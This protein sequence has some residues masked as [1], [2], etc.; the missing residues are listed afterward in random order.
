MPV[1]TKHQGHIRIGRTSPDGKIFSLQL[2][3]TGQIFQEGDNWISYCKGLDLS[4]CGRTP[5]EALKNTKDAITLFFKSCISRGVL[6]PALTELGWE[7]SSIT[8]QTM[9]PSSSATK[10]LKKS[11]LSIPSDIVPAFI[12]DQQKGKNWSGHVEI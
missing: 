9:K 7:I 10:K 11:S 12:I 8:K 1:E 6:E 5:E 4:T 2:S 3:L